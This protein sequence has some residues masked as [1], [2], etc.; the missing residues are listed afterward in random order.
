MTI[1]LLD[2]DEDDCCDG[3]TTGVGTATVLKHVAES[4]IQL[5]V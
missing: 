4:D 1:E 5:L 2:D 3:V